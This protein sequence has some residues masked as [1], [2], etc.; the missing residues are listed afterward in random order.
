[1]KTIEEI[2]SQFENTYDYFTEKSGYSI[3]D[4][5]S[6][7]KEYAKQEA[8][9]FNDYIA[10]NGYHLDYGERWRSNGGLEFRLDDIYRF[11][12]NET[13]SAY[14]RDFTQ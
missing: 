2:L 6:A 8:I 9:L 7:M 5:A 13:V 11:F 4:V 12:K 3:E 10:K 14:L 1:M